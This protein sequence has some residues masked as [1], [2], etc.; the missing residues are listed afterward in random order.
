MKL[1]KGKSKDIVEGDMTPMIDMVFQLI[2]F[3]MVLVNF[4]EADQDDRVQLPKSELA[5]PAEKP[6]ENPI[7]VNLG[8]DDKI[9]LTGQPYTFDSLPSALQTERSIIQDG[10]SDPITVIIRAH[11]KAPTGSVQRI[12]EICQDENFENFALRAEEDN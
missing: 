3:F 9:Y 11:G 1:D 5:K 6:I 8:L 7:T 10:S 4:S 2:A 12:I